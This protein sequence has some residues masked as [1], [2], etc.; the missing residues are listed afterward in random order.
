MDLSLLHVQIDN[1]YDAFTLD[2]SRNTQS[3]HPG[4]DEQHSTGGSLR[5]R[6]MPGVGAATL[7]VIGAY[8][9]TSVKYGFDGDWGNPSALGALHL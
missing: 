8:A 1:G 6:P 3:D 4:V 2:N 9:D 7:T 5:A